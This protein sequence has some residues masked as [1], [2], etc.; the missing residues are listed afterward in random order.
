MNERIF[1]TGHFGIISNLMDFAG[2]ALA[3]YTHIYIFLRTSFFAL[4]LSSV[5]N[6]I[7]KQT[8]HNGQ[9]LFFST[10]AKFPFDL[11]VMFIS[12]TICAHISL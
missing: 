1:H 4:S 9:K 2:M 8:R 12:E 5:S 7:G 3:F 10:R 11:R 6:F